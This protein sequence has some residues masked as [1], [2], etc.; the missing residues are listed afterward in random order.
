MG[1]QQAFDITFEVVEISRAR[2]LAPLLLGHRAEQHAADAVELLEVV[3]AGTEALA[4]FEQ[5][6]PRLLAVQVVRE[7]LDQARP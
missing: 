1:R 7:R 5:P 2:R 4:E 6:D 3:A